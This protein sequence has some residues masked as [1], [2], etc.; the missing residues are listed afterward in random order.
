MIRNFL[1]QFIKRLQYVAEENKPRA[2]EFNN[3]NYQDLLNVQISVVYIDGEECEVVLYDENGNRYRSNYRT[4]ITI[5]NLYKI[6]PV[7]H[8]SLFVCCKW[9]KGKSFD[10]AMETPDNF[11]CSPVLERNGLILGQHFIPEGWIHFYAG[12]GSRYFIKTDMFK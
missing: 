12:F 5:E 7:I 10:E 3:D 6:C 9:E 1:L 11:S 2:I 8:E 4:S